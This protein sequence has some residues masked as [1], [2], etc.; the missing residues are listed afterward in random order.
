MALSVAAPAKAADLQFKAPVNR[1]ETRLWVEGGAHFTGGDNIQYNAADPFFGGKGDGR[2][3]V[4]GVAFGVFPAFGCT[5]QGENEQ[6]PILIPK[7]LNDPSVYPWIG[8]SGAA[9]FDHRFAGTR[10]HVNG[11]ARAGVAFGKD[12][13][14]NSLTIL[15][16]D[17]GG[18]EGVTFS[19]STETKLTEWYWHADLGVGYDVFT[20][21]A[22]MQVKFGLR[23]AEIA[24]RNK[25]ES[26]GSL[27]VFDPG[28]VPAGGATFNSTRTVF[29]SFLGGGPRLGVEGEI[30]LWA[31]WT[32]DYKG[33]AAI[34]FGN[35]KIAGESF[36]SINI[37]GPGFSFGANLAGPN[38]YWS[39]AIYVWNFD[40]QAGI[41]WWVTPNWKMAASYR[42]DAFLDALRQNP[43]DLLPA[44]S[45]DRYY[46]GPK[47]T[48]TGRWH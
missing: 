43:D 14:T 24:A 45:I 11:E 3:P 17:G 33:D 8:I 38:E 10:W 30:P 25:T 4:A 48:L 47:L 1:G 2:V 12:D 34:L 20:G 27:S 7:G 39:K 37:A 29:R 21:P 41:G 40:L 6:C 42:V 46:H 18:L 19:G 44:Q 23:I 35:T 36:H 26:S 9:G 22:T 32:L 16:D 28:L 5:G 31:N 15:D 13:F